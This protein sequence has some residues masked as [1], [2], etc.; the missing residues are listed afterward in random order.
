M[1]KGLEEKPCGEW[2]RRLGLF[3][4]EK[5]SLRED[6]A[7][8]AGGLAMLLRDPSGPCSCESSEAKKGAGGKF[9]EDDRPELGIR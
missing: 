1:V 5:R 2:L 3:S 7:A 6:L 4:L 9:Q 8:G